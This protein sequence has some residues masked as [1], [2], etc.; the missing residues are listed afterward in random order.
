[1]ADDTTFKLGE[2]L[3]AQGAIRRS[4]GLAEELLPVDAFVG[5]ISDEI[6]ASRRDGRDDQALADLIRDTTGK[7]V[8]VEDIARFYVPPEQ[9]PH[10]EA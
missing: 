6:E 10:P 8:T 2:A 4:L 5:M 1:M 3:A 9:R 7:A